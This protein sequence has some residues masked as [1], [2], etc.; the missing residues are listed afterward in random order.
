MGSQHKEKPR[1]RVGGGSGEQGRIGE[2][3]GTTR[4]HEGFRNLA[5]GRPK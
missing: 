1:S 3:K 2:W 4:K 5:E